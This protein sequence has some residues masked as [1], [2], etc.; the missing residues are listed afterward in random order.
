MVDMQGNDRV[1][2]RTLYVSMAGALVLAIWGLVM[3]FLSG[4]DAILLDGLFNMISAAMSFVSIWVTRLVRQRRTAN[5]PL[6]FFAYE[7]LYIV[8]KGGSILVLVV[9]AVMT[10]VEVMLAGG[11]E[12]KL[13]LMTLYVGPA[14]LACSLLY[15]ITRRGQRQTKSEIL[16][17]EAQGWLINAV[18]SGSIG[19]AFVGV[20][21]LEGTAYAWTARYADQVL[22]IA[23]S[24]LFIH[25]PIK[26]FLT[27][28]RELLLTAPSRDHITP[29]RDALAPFLARYEMSMV[30]L[31]VMKMGRHTWVTLFVD[32]LEDRVEV[33]ALMRFKRAASEVVSS[34]HAN[35]STEVILERA[36][37]EE[38]GLVPEP[39]A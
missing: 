24:L 3:A 6:G 17:A 1:E 20:M 15:W 25:D 29:V 23:L 21:L 14:V 12:P 19:L 33:A 26:L 2:V 36:S 34:V 18:V 9:A 7:S 31:E 11:R 28:F 39:A 38:P 35:A 27:G 10:S 13:G 5:H 37:E 8:F 16:L 30:D 22:V 32:P 4:S